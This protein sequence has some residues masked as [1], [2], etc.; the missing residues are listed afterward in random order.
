MEYQCVTKRRKGTHA[1][2]EEAGHVEVVGGL[3][4][5]TGAHLV[6]PLA[7]ENLPGPGTGGG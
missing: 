1:V 5:D 4:T 6:L 7:G 2:K 3:D